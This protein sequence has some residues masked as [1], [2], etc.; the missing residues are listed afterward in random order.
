MATLTT[1]KR[2]SVFKHRF[3]NISAAGTKSIRFYGVIETKN[4]VGAVGGGMFQTN[5]TSAGGDNRLEAYMTITSH[6]NVYYLNHS[7]TPANN[8]IAFDY[9]QDLVIQPGDIMTI[10]LDNIDLTQFSGDA[11]GNPIAGNFPG[12]YLTQWVAIQ[13]VTN[14]LNANFGGGLRSA[15]FFGFAENVYGIKPEK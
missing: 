13:Y 6:A 11:G 3:I 5:V 2:Y 4:Y 14:A 15:S 8:C 9:S 7:A 1:T 10:V 12:T